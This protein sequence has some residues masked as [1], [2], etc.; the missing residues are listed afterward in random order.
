VGGLAQSFVDDRQH[1]FQIAIDVSVPEAQYPEAFAGEVIVAQRV[2]MCM[3]IKIMLA[4]IDL[5]DDAM[6]ETDEIYDMTVARCLAAEVK[7]SSS[8]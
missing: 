5:D 6:F 4:A 3:S 7:T 2:A 1:T 8:P